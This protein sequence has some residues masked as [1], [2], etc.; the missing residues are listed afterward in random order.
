MDIFI[1]FFLDK[2]LLK[3]WTDDLDTQAY[4]GELYNDFFNHYYLVKFKLHEHKKL[5]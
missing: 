2:C 1:T 3:C 4:F 5:N